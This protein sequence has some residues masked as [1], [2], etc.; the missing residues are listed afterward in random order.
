MEITFKHSDGQI[1]K[2]KVNFN[3]N[4]KQILEEHKLN[5]GGGHNLNFLY[6]GSVLGP[7][8]HNETVYEIAGKVERESKA[9]FSR[10]FSKFALVIPLFPSEKRI[11]T[12]RPKSAS[13]LNKTI[14]YFLELASIK[15]F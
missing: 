2:R 13:W 10:A 9:I 14:G 5:Y 15:G 8:L 3:D 1:I 7:N 12:R 11:D 4:M 6:N